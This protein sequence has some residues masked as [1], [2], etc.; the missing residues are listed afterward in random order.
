VAES[1]HST[2]PENLVGYFPYR[3][4]DSLDATIRGRDDKDSELRLMEGS[5]E[6]S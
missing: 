2:E 6:L 4:P 1:I 5:L 3:A